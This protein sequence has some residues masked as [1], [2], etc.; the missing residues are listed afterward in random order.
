MLEPRHAFSGH[1]LLS[2]IV[3]S[4]ENSVHDGYGL[5][6]D[7]IEIFNAG[8]HS[9]NL[10]SYALTDDPDELDKWEFPSVVLG[11][12]E[13]L[14]V[15]ASGLD[16]VDPSGGL[17]TNFSLSASGEYLALVSPGGSV[18]SAFGSPSQDFPSLVKNQSYGLPFE[19][20][21]TQVVTPTSP[22]SY[23]V[24]TSNAHGHAWT[25]LS[26]DDSSWTSSM[27]AVGLTD[28]TNLYTPHITT[29]LPAGTTSAYLRIPFEVSDPSA[30]LGTLSAK[31]DDGFVAYLN[32]ERIASFSAP[33][34]TAFDSLATEFRPREAAIE[35]V[36]FDVS[37]FSH[38]LE[39][40]ENVLAIHLLN[41]PEG[42]SIDALMAPTLTI[43]SGVMVASESPAK[44][45]QATPGMPNTL[46]ASSEVE[47]S[48]TTGVFTTTFELVLSSPGGEPIRYTL[49]G[50]M[51]TS[52]SPL[53]TAPIS[54]SASVQVRARTYA[55]DGSVGDTK[56]ESFSLLGTV[57]DGF[58]SDLPIIVLENFGQGLPDR[59]FQSG[60]L[61][62]YEPS[63]ETGRTS[64]DSTPTL[65][66]LTGQHRRGAS[67]YNHPK[68]NLALEFR[69]EHGF[70]KS[71][72]ILGM[73][74]ESD[75]V[76]YAPYGTD[77]SLIR[78]AVMY[79]L[80]QQQTGY[81]VRTR[82]VEL[83]Y[84]IYGGELDNFDYRGVYVLMEKI[85]ID[86]NRVGIDGVDRSD[87]SESDITGGGYLFKIDRNEG[88]E[89]SSWDS[90][91]TPNVS[92]HAHVDPE[93]SDLTQ[94]QVD[95]LRGY[96]D[97]F[98][99]A[100]SGPNYRDPL[101]GYASYIDV[102]GW[103]D[104]HLFRVFSRETDNIVLSEH[105]YLAGEGQLTYGPAWDF[106]RSTGSS[107]AGNK[108]A[109]GWNGNVANVFGYGW[110]GRLW[111]DLDFRH[112]WADRWAELRQTVLSDENLTN[113]VLKHA[114]TVRESQVRDVARW[115]AG[116]PTGGAYSD[117][118]TTGW[119]AEISN[120]KNWLLERA[121]WMDSQMVTAP[122]ISFA[123]TENSQ[124]RLV[125]LQAP[126][127]GPI[128]YT[129]DGS[130]P[131][132]AGNGAAPN[133]I[134]YTGPFTVGTADEVTVRTTGSVS[135]WTWSA[136]VSQRAVE[137]IPA[138][139][140]NLRI[141]ELHYNPLDPTPGELALVPGADN[142]SFEFIELV[143]TSASYIDLSGVHFDEGITFDFST[144]N[145]QILAP[146][147]VV[148]VVNDVAAFAAR[149]GN[150]LLVAGEYSGNLNGSGEEIELEAGDD[151]IIDAVDYSDDSPWPEAADGD[152]P[153]LE[154]IS[155][156]SDPNLGQSWRASSADHGTPGVVDNLPLWGD[157]NLDGI[158]NLGDY[159]VWRDALGATGNFV[160][161]ASG[162]GV[163][164]AADYLVW[165]QNFGNTAPPV[166][167]VVAPAPV[168]TPPQ[169]SQA[170]ESPVSEIEPVPH[171]AAAADAALALF[172]SPE[173]EI[174]PATSLASRS[175]SDKTVDSGS[176]I[177]AELL[178]AIAEVSEVDAP[179]YDYAPGKS[180][181]EQDEALELA[182]ALDWDLIGE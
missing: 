70:D 98:V 108:S 161:D 26:F 167:L 15:F 97:E 60:S 119:D 67:T 147:E 139:S 10:G 2:E 153:S 140:A 107:G 182:L 23:H 106:D 79:D 57:H 115:P 170:T 114:D 96:I 91:G 64:L 83:F 51:P 179:A 131:R 124:E 32:G 34:S 59:E 138:S 150:N 27:A 86:E 40:G 3:A 157:Y 42:E 88:E 43:G 68:P 169:R 165:K 127:G 36:V 166:S 22:A 164:D 35:S 71:V 5:A 154:L 28:S 137:A 104:H 6:Q 37:R 82:F 8:D 31:F 87:V 173:S 65:T 117:P 175:E 7:W 45:M 24:P 21:Y 158:V 163:V 66:S 132:A 92:V 116:A 19:S 77:R 90:G 109:E 122:T 174:S 123:D 20:V 126:L 159:T 93:R 125:T 162:N 95:H 12:G 136:P 74:E 81:A 13:Y 171:A 89:D 55:V 100:L 143:N 172:L 102:D 49:D 152:G 149:Y 111:T 112:G 39:L 118:G 121:A 54:V 17:H 105:M 33:G 129:L 113:T 128:Y 141:S 53:Y 103:I 69:D 9:V 155:Y 44:L 11:P 151:S 48:R 148:L 120:L 176:G 16:R 72:S 181:V 178:L 134:L 25:E 156:T 145:V 130:D 144:S 52:S 160:L 58:T 99:T 133:A 50:T 110:W 85:K 146:G 4:N 29:S 63:A 41:S 78:N 62:L 46:A 135:Y 30:V 14:V 75:W 142:N 73:P 38:L 101:T 94:S 76:L 168:V 18:V 84:N 56:T 47:F 80:S 61:A 1:P 180:A 177:G